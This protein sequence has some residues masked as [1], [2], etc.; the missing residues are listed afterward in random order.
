MFIPRIGEKILM[1]KKFHESLLELFDLTHCLEWLFGKKTTKKRNN[2]VV[3]TPFWKFEREFNR[4]HV[5]VAQYFLTSSKFT[6]VSQIFFAHF[7]V[8]H[9]QKFRFFLIV[10]ILILWYKPYKISTLESWK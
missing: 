8:L 5:L 9:S 3:K 10:G 6:K 1:V 7:G 2:E 4:P